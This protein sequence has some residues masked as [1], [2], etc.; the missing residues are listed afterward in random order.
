MGSFFST[1]STDTFIYIPYI[2][3]QAWDTEWIKA[4]NEAH[5]KDILRVKMLAEHL[6]TAQ[7]G[8]VTATELFFS[9]FSV[10]IEIDTC[11]DWKTGHLPK[12]KLFIVKLRLMRHTDHKNGTIY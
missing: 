9:N 4:C 10:Y 12:P 8:K 1:N 6:Q 5:N 2:S 7:N 11:V 3:L